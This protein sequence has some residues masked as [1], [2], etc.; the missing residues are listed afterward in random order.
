MCCVGIG[1]LAQLTSYNTISHN[2]IGHF[3]YTGISVGWSWGYL[4]IIIFNFSI[5]YMYYILFWLS[6]Y[7]FLLLFQIYNP[8]SAH[9]NTVS[10][11]HIYDIGKNTLSDII[12][13]NYYYNY[14]HPI[15]F[16]I[17]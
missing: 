9:N 8:S 10:F 6:L 2:E 11:N 12:N 7:Y 17:L 16:L 15:S 5:F 13:Y 4:I 1:V 14:F 3:R